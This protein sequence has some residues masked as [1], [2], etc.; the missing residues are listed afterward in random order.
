M[1]GNVIVRL[2]V[3]NPVTV[4][5]NPKPRFELLNLKILSFVELTKLHELSIYLFVTTC[6][7]AAVSNVSVVFPGKVITLLPP[8]AVA[9][10]RVLRASSPL[11]SNIICFEFVAVFR[12]VSDESLIIVEPVD[13]R[14]VKVAVVAPN[15]VMVAEV[16][17]KF[18]NVPFVV[19]IL[20][21][22]G[23]LESLRAFFL[24]KLVIACY[25]SLHTKKGI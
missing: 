25:I 20:V 14:F 21:G 13:V 4:Y 6:A 22:S 10:V 5:V 9:K 12:I 19:T 17:V 11:A 15:V 16:L 24:M 3:A 8:D 2:A 18:V 1:S 7:D 23:I